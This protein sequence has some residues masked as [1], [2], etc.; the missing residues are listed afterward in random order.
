M[1][2]LLALAV[3]GFAWILQQ[4]RRA[5]NE[6]PGP[7]PSTRLLPFI[8]PILAPLEAGTAGYSAASLEELQ[9]SFRAGRD[10]LGFDDGDI[11]G[12]AATMAQILQEAL[13][14]RDRHVERLLRLGSP[15]EGATP[16]PAARTELTEQE[17]RH[18]ELAVAISWQR[19]SGTYRNRVDELWY[20]LLRLE[21]G[22]FRSGSASPA[23]MPDL[24]PSAVPTDE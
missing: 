11:H 2:A 7:A 24:P 5:P 6:L 21:Q 10:Q 22:R 19:N 3:L 23:M 16:D 1:L 12:T 14:D 8:D 15:V 13:E 17:R 18:L 9:S 4:E 20:R